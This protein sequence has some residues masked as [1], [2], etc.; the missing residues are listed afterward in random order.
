VV[1]CAAAVVLTVAAAVALTVV[2][3]VVVALAA[4]TVAA[5]AD[6]G[7][8]DSVVATVTGEAPFLRLFFPDLGLESLAPD[9]AVTAALEPISSGRAGVLGASDGGRYGVVAH[10]RE[11]LLRSAGSAVRL[12]KSVS[13][14]WGGMPPVVPARPARLDDAFEI[15]VMAVLRDAA[16]VPLSMVGGFFFILFFT[17][18]AFFSSYVDVRFR[19][20]AREVGTSTGTPGPGK[21]LPALAGTAWLELGSSMAYTWTQYTHILL[22]KLSHFNFFVVLVL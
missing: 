16:P 12:L 14:M 17:A 15:L 20:S 19:A 13:G 18:L 10:D 22:T 6:A 4:D 3:A 2:A 5:A 11:D 9:V 21:K 7:C 1:V 8:A